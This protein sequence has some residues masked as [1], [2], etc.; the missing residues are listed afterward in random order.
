LI[1][2]FEN[3]L[4]IQNEK[5]LMEIIMEMAMSRPPDVKGYYD[6]GRILHTGQDFV[7]FAPGWSL[8]D[9]VVFGQFNNHLVYSI[10]H[11]IQYKI[12]SI[13]FALV[14]CGFHS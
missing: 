13:D 3:Q 11:F 8:F 4:P 12:S 6:I 1:I 7:E 10:I 9:K 2:E 14:A 5:D